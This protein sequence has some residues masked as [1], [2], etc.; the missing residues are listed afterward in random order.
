VRGKKESINYSEISE[1]QYTVTIDSHCILN[2][3]DLRAFK[4]N[5]RELS[6]D[7]DG[8]ANR[9]YIFDGDNIT[10]KSET[11]L[12]V[13]GYGNKPKVLMVFGNPAFHSVKN[14]MFFFS[15]A[16]NHRHG[17]WG[18]L[19]KANLIK[20][21]RFSDDNLF[22]ARKREAEERKRLISAGNASDLFTLGMTTFYSFPTPV[23]GRFQNVL[24]VEKL[25]K[26]VLEDI[27]RFE[28]HRF[29]N[30]EFAQDAILVFVQKSSYE[31]FRRHC[32]QKT[33]YWP[34]RGKNSS[35]EYLY[36]K[37]IEAGGGSK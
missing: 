8:G 22:L 25:F 35:G 7:C 17:M 21:V 4:A 3:E 26:P 31:A 27:I 12:P 13:G 9:I 24:G 19:Q 16:N 18:R 15:K 30:C 14:G 33:I 36:K 28:V 2:S 11:I 32:V 20:H 5:I 1:G 6:N 37:L 29:Q 34:L 23:K 10:Y